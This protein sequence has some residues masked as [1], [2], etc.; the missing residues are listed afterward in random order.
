MSNTMGKVVRSTL[1]SFI[2]VDESDDA[3]PVK[4]HALYHVPM[5]NIR[6]LPRY[7]LTLHYGNSDLPFIK[8]R[9]R[10]D[11][12]ER[13][14]RLF[15]VKVVVD[16]SNRA[17]GAAAM[18]PTVSL[19]SHILPYRDTPIDN[20]PTQVLNLNRVKPEADAY[21]RELIADKIAELE[22]TDHEI[23]GWRL[24]KL[25]GR[26]PHLL[27]DLAF[28]PD[29]HHVIMFVW[30]CDVPGQV[31]P[32]TQDRIIKGSRM[33]TLYRR[34]RVLEAATMN[35]DFVKAYI[36]DPDQLSAMVDQDAEFGVAANAVRVTTPG[37]TV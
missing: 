33:A 29:M 13:G 18:V 3:L 1:T 25:V 32:V 7:G 5:A 9:Q 16:V 26:Y 35:S 24:S 12:A 15:E 11:A 4:E 30:E 19:E 31:N 27:D 10:S 20:R 37:M 36:P 34:E 2:P 6:S 14:Q 28:H 22:A 17:T 21:M 23:E 8:N